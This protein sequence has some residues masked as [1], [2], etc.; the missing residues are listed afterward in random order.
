MTGATSWVGMA[1][2]TG[3]AAIP[4][5]A[6]HLSG[7]LPGQLGGSAGGLVPG[8]WI[9]AVLV[10]R[11]AAVLLLPARRGLPRGWAAGTSSAGASRS[12][13]HGVVDA[14]RSRRAEQRTAVPEP[15][16]GLL[17]TEVAANIAIG[18]GMLVNVNHHGCRE[19]LILRLTDSFQR[20]NVVR[21]KAIGMQTEVAR[22]RILYLKHQMR[23]LHGPHILAF[24][25]IVCPNLR[26]II[27]RKI[28][29]Y[30]QNIVVIND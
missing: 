30:A 28:A 15:D 18:V 5:P 12:S 29:Q 21:K 17:L 11:A 27:P 19:R 20:M 3:P 24:S 23:Q 25:P 10:A 14:L 7:Q 13:P 26:L 8:A 9:A 1:C 6:G 4:P 16:L 22:M 2:V